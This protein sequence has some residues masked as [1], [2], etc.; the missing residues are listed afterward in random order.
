VGTQELSG[1]LIGMGSYEPKGWI[2]ERLME[3]LGGDF[4][5]LT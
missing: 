5:T 2:D 3:N 1:E 4:R